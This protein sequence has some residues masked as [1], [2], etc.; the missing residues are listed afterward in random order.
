MNVFQ[1]TWKKGACLSTEEENTV[2]NLSRKSDSSAN[3][4]TSN[5][6][7]NEQDGVSPNEPPWPTNGGPLG[8][9]IGSMS[10]LLIGAFLGTTLLI[11]YRVTGIVLT[12]LLTFILAVLGWKIGRGVFREYAPPTSRR[13]LRGR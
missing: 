9:L 4:G 3:A 8:C 12:V 7:N 10:G 5:P 6:K 11:P 13:R 2:S 1:T